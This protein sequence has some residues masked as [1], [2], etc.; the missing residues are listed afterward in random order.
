M[1]AITNDQVAAIWREHERWCEERRPDWQLA[2]SCYRTKMWA[3]GRP[4]G[5]DEATVR[6]KIPVPIEVNRV[7]PFMEA[8]VSSMFMRRPR[9]RVQ[10]PG[11]FP[12]KAGRKP[13]ARETGDQVQAMLDAWL[14]RQNVQ[15]VQMDA[16][17]LALLYGDAG[18]RAGAESD[19]DDRKE[20]PDVLDRVWCEA[21]PPWELVM[22]RKAKRGQERYRGHV[23][24]RLLSCVREDIGDPGDVA[25]EPLRD[26]LVGGWRGGEPSNRGLDMY[27]RVL[28]FY[29]LGDEDSEP[30]QAFYL[31]GSGGSVTPIGERAAVPW[32]HPDGCPA[33]PIVPVVLLHDPEAPLS[34]IP[35]VARIV[36]LN[37]EQNLT[38]SVV[39]SMARRDAARKVG[40][41][42]GQ[43]DVDAMRALESDDDFAIVII[44]QEGKDGPVPIEGAVRPLAIPQIPAS[45]PAALGV[46]ERGWSQAAG[47]S[48][49]AVGKN[50]RTNTSAAEARLLAMSDARS[51]SQAQ[52]AMGNSIAALGRLFLSIVRADVD[53]SKAKALQFV[54]R[55]Q[56]V[57]LEADSLGLPWEVEI[58]DAGSTPV[59][60]EARREEFASIQQPLL[61][62][63]RLAFGGIGGDPNQPP[64]D[65]ATQVIAGLMYQK[66]VED[67]RLGEEF[68]RDAIASKLVEVMQ[69][70]QKLQPPAPPPLDPAAQM[71]AGPR[72]IAAVPGGP[73]AAP[74]PLATPGGL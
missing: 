65:P 48:D 18:F 12:V 60:D 73:P 32:T 68:N 42:E 35:A 66:M 25:G 56:T 9:S 3:E 64:V 22:D 69:A 47:M 57:R 30:S 16:Y 31:V 27:V 63:G 36:N 1:P 51:A 33:V 41:A 54:H 44:G 19:E 8:M 11:V 14:V 4:Y 20:R 50:L 2:R 29:D 24:L 39:L 52:T 70:A 15:Q 37:V 61:T 67:F 59:G 58:A 40:V 6:K 62:L 38:M 17:S 45:I 21:I 49:T 5:W 72:P 71:I 74:P 43:L 55:G 13:K 23:S 34:G 28:E 7:L 53:G 10:L 46:L 26:F